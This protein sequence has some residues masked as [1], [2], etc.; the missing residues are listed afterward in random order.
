MNLS[1][2]WD[3]FRLG[4][5]FVLYFFFFGSCSSTPTAVLSRKTRTTPASKLLCGAS[6]QSFDAQSDSWSRREEFAPAAGGCARAWLLA[7]FCECPLLLTGGA[8]YCLQLLWVIFPL[9]VCHWSARRVCRRV[10]RPPSLSVHRGVDNN[11]VYVW[12][13]A[14]SPACRTAYF[15]GHSAPG[16]ATRGCWLAMLA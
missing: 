14:W 11:K 15:V 3:F 9:A 16:F 8:L 4:K 1:V 13:E 12:A 2:V 6:G 5:K 7:W 10:W